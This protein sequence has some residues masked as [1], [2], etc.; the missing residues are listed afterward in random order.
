MDTTSEAIA[1]ER[2]TIRDGVPFDPAWFAI[3][4]W[5]GIVAG[6]TLLAASLLQAAADQGWV[7]TEPAFRETEA[8]PLVDVATF[9]ADAFSFEHDVLWNLAIRD[10]LFPIAFMAI[11]VVGLATRRI[12]GARR[13][14]T[15]LL[16]TTLLVGAM[17]SAMNPLIYLSQTTWWRE[18]GWT[19]DPPENMVAVGRAGEAIMNLTRFFQTS[20]ALLLAIGL[21]LL[22]SV[23]RSTHMLPSGLGVVAVVLGV[24]L[25]IA[26]IA[27]VFDVRWLWDIGTGAFGVI[28]G[29][30]LLV[31]LGRSLWAAR[32]GSGLGARV[33]MST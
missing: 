5:A 11:I 15:E 32:T 21:L 20:G 1:V 9:Y 7:G 10:T 8:G 26:A 30:I 19:A 16:A 2:T 27:E 33:S 17:F 24:G 18:T 13:A 3:G 31:W 25:A 29:P 28:L 14:D 23:I 6:A 4:R 22:W 12:V